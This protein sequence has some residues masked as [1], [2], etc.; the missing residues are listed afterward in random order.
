MNKKNEIMKDSG[1]WTRSYIKLEEESRLQ[2]WFLLSGF[3]VFPPHHDVF[4]GR[5]AHHRLRW[6]NAKLS[7]DRWREREEEG[8]SRKP[9]AQSSF[10]TLKKGP[11][12]I[13]GDLLTPRN[14]LS[15]FIAPP[16]CSAHPDSPRQSLL[17]CGHSWWPQS[18][19]LLMVT[20][21]WERGE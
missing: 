4:L 21:I 16:L 14:K 20:Y 15:S 2:A 13:L 19:C 5:D 12:T 1:L 11:K 17:T 3:L 9:S 18:P 8:A 10:L 6:G 7:S